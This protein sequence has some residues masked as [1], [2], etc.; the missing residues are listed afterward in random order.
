MRAIRTALAVLTFATLLASCGDSPETAVDE[1]IHG[2]Q[3]ALLARDFPK[4][5]SYNTAETTAKLLAAVRTQA[6][7]A[8]TCEQ[9]FEAIYAEPGPA[10]SA[11]G[12]G[13]TFTVRSV[14]VTGDYATVNWTAQLDGQERPAT[15]TM[16]LV[17]GEWKL[18]AG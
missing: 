11:D 10:A 7:D 18:L 15:S 5:C 1:A 17:D 6:I 16:R 13:Q 8:T 4:A 9:A 14:A 3:Q 12:I 2:Y